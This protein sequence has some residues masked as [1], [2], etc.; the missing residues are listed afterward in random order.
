M[1]HVAT[2]VTHNHIDQALALYT[3]MKKFQDITLHILIVNPH[4]EKLDQ[5][6]KVV[7]DSVQ[8]HLTEELTTDHEVG[9][10]SR[11]IIAKYSFLSLEDMAFPDH[12]NVNDYLRWSL[13]SVFVQTLLRKCP[14]ILYCDCDL[15]FY[16]DFDFLLKQFEQ[17]QILLSPHWR[18]IR[19]I[20][21]NDYKFN[22]IHGIYNAGFVG[23]RND[24]TDMLAWWAEMV[25]MECSADASM[26]GTYVDQK[27]LDIVPL[28]F[29]DV[30]IIRHKG[31]NVAGWNVKH[32]KREVKGDKVFVEGD[33]LVFVHFSPVTISNIE[34]G[35]D[36]GLAD[37]Y[38]EYQA[39]L[40]AQRLNLMR[41][42][43]PECI[44]QRQAE[45]D[46]KAVI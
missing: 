22:F 2:I 8:I 46:K 26:H 45:D 42:G 41:K 19:P 29:D 4:R 18:V 21:D 15:Y 43:M 3:S 27:Y 40:K 5:L 25:S 31:C 32:L 16:S 38:R 13:K 14:H 17:S 9:L 33:P 12:I 37:A 1:T 44:S 28:Y 20:T 39:E 7:G 23:L 30:H 35:I 11:Y 34:S 10:T 24:A 36:I 6:R